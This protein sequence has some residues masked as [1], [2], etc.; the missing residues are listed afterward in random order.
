MRQRLHEIA[1][2]LLAKT[3][4]G[5]VNWQHAPAADPRRYAVN[6]LSA[7]VIVQLF[8]VA[9]A[10]GVLSLRI[11]P[12]LNDDREYLAELRVAEGEPG[13][14]ELLDLFHAAQEQARGWGK[15]LETI[16]AMIR[17]DNPIG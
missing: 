1:T 9:G 13:W 16:E 17:S 15:I 7:Y 6:L 12:N 3:G 14:E 8:G 4:R 2:L 11:Q 5:Q 10:P